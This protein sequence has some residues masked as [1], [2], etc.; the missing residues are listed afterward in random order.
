MTVWNAPLSEGWNASLPDAFGPGVTYTALGHLH[1]AQ[2]VSGRENV[3]YAGTPIPM[4]FAEKN[5][6]QGVVFIEIDNTVKIEQA[7]CFSCSLVE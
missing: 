5:N 2:R 1:R 3:R 7:T 6:R 4:S